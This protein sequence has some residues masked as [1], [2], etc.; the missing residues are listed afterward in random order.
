MICVTCFVM[1]CDAMS[2]V[3]AE[4]DVGMPTL[5]AQKYFKQLLTGVVSICVI[6]LYFARKMFV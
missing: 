5:E 4:P 2:F 1:Y 6:D 3:L